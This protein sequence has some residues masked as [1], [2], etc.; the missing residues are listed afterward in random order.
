M[1]AIR[2]RGPL[3]SI[4][5]NGDRSRRYMFYDFFAG[6]G[7]ATLGLSSAWDCVWANDIDPKKASVYRANFGG[8]HFHEG[9]VGLVRSDDLPFPADLAWA[10]FPCQDLSLAGWRRGISAERSGAFWAFWR[11]MND[12]CRA[13]ARPP[14]IVVENVVGL[15]HGD[16]FHGLCEALGAL[17]M[18][19]GAVVVD[20][21]HFVPQSRPRV[22]LVAVDSRIDCR[23]LTLSDPR[24]LWTPNSLPRAVDRLPDELRSLWR[25]WDL[26]YPRLPRPGIDRIVEEE[27]SGVDWHSSEETDYLLSMMSPANAR[28]V[29]AARRSKQRHIG[30]LYRRI[31]EG[32]QR[33]EVRFDGIA[34]CLRTPKGGSSRQ[35]VFVVEEGRVRS[36][37]LSPREAARLMGAPDGFRLPANYNDAY[38][39]MGDAVAVPVVRWLS[40]SLLEPLARLD[41]CDTA[42]VSNSTDLQT[43][44]R[45]SEE[46][47]DQWASAQARVGYARS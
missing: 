6:A 24:P 34:G 4:S 23:P 37:L 44:L 41:R 2:G 15:L 29:L 17:G 18:Q 45:I 38:K 43:A 19:F 30:F 21:R 28:K 14:L 25:W 47:A 1:R 7:L 46:R 22:F 9:D 40:H 32:Q 5:A 31:R 35:T 26:A 16:S 12:Q 39:A 33:A 27:P 20:A 13:G 10:S 11:L 3:T 8:T 36:R 42:T